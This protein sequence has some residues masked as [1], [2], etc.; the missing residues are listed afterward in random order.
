MS[1][2]S[3]AEESP[4]SQST[5]GY[6]VAGAHVFAPALLRLCGWR[7]Q[8]KNLPLLIAGLLLG[9]TSGREFVTAVV[10]GVLLNLLID[11]LNRYSDRVEDEIDHP[12][13]TALC[14]LVGYRRLQSA[15][16]GA[17]V[18]YACIALL[19][20]LAGTHGDARVVLVLWFGALGM[21]IAYSVGPRI[22]AQ[23]MPSALATNLSPAGMLLLG[24]SVSG[25]MRDAGL[26]ALLLVLFG[27]SVAGFKDL[28]SV[29]GDKLVGFE[30]IGT[31]IRSWGAYRHIA[32]MTAPYVVMVL[33][34]VTG[35][36]PTVALTLLGLVPVVLLHGRATR[37]AV[38]HPQMV[39]AA[40]LG[41]LYLLISSQG[42]M[43][44]LTTPST[45]LLLVTLTAIATWW[46]ITKH[47]SYD[48]PVDVLVASRNVL[49]RTL[50]TTRRS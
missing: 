8:A 25:A 22:K 36:F 7:W 34:V 33:F 14:R 9:N 11:L 47:L 39:E 5:L 41:H 44:V 16:V 46:A 38:T 10:G 24:A 12:Y 2:A 21:A 30:S 1:A 31:R 15:A 45:V 13:R 37:K 28:A 18:L 27:V 19:A 3:P 6:G 23:T 4:T 26:P 50:L 35:T 20:G 29:E 17:G 42:L 43:V 48:E 32:L 49:A 40:E